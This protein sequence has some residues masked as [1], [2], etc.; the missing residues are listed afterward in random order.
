MCA[1]Y[2]QVTAGLLKFAGSSFDAHDL[3]ATAARSLDRCEDF[4]RLHMALAGHPAIC[5]RL[6]NAG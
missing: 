4:G 6:R 2:Q 5:E 3:L 1:T